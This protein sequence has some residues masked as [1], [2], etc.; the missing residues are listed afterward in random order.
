MFFVDEPPPI[1]SHWPVTIG[2]VIYNLRSALHHAAYEHSV[3]DLNRERPGRGQ[4]RGVP[5]GHGTRKA[6]DEVSRPRVAWSRR[7]DKGTHR[8]CAAPPRARQVLSP[9]HLRGDYLPPRPAQRTLQ[10]RE[11]SPPQLRRRVGG[12]GSHLQGHP[13]PDVF[14]GALEPGRMVAKMGLLPRVRA[15]REHATTVLLQHPARA[16]GRAIGHAGRPLGHELHG[17][18]CSGRPRPLTLAQRSAEATPGTAPWR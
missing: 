8:A 16:S 4:E 17:G 18:A 9:H 3:I 11:A 7:R 15:L 6:H 12:P 13:A 5:P 2:E 1:P 14:E 10:H